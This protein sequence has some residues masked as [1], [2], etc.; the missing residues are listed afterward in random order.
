MP[1][2]V[3]LARGDDRV[4]GVLDTEVRPRVAGAGSRE[5]GGTGGGG[6]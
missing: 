3:R 1:R 6:F 2:A 4:A 5:G